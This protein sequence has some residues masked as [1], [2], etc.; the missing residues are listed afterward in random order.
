MSLEKHSRRTEPGL[1][2][3]SLMLLHLR[4]DPVQVIVLQTS[5]CWQ[6]HHILCAQIEVTISNCK[7]M[8]NVSYPN[9]KKI[10]L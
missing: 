2:A 6:M 8:Q 3:K 1:F 10:K 4:T 9:K 5:P 7:A